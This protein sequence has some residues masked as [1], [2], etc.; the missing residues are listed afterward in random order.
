MSLN[1]K[2]GLLDLRVGR[3]RLRE[4]AIVHLNGAVAAQMH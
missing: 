1:A 4:L 2:H 3:Q